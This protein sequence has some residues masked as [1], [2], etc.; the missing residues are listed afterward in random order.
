M[1]SL[2]HMRLFSRILRDKTFQH[3]C[4]LSSRAASTSA[5]QARWPPLRSPAAKS[6]SSAAAG[7]AA[8]TPASGA[9]R[10]PA[11]SAVPQLQMA[12]GVSSRRKTWRSV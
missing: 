12:A 9:G 4:A 7:D 3:T 1:H 6:G 10:S 11:A 2:S 8:A 5:S